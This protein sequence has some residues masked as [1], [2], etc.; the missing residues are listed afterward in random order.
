[1]HPSRCVD[2]SQLIVSVS[3]QTGSSFLC[4]GGRFKALSGSLKSKDPS[5]FFSSAWRASSISLLLFRSSSS[6]SRFLA[7]SLLP[8]RV[9]CPYKSYI[10]PQ[11]YF[12]LFYF[13]HTGLL[14]CY[15]SRLF[16]N[17]LVRHGS[18]GVSKKKNE[19]VIDE[20]RNNASAIFQN[21]LVS[22]CKIEFV[23]CVKNP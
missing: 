13:S 18:R 22:C 21:C 4:L 23:Q 16:W 10:H 11:V 20:I 2:F 1:V 5:T 14:F 6:Q 15:I 9:P 7:S 8:S 12:I 3:N 19:L 17:I